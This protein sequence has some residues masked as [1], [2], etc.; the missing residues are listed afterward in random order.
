[1]AGEDP[2]RGN[3][4]T[5]GNATSRGGERKRGVWIGDVV[6]CGT[7]HETTLSW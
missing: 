3:T 4:T 5:G 1:M 7:N 2:C 6:R